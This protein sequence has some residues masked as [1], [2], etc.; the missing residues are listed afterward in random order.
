MYL[1]PEGRSFVMHCDRIARE[2]NKNT[3]PFAT[4]FDTAE[5]VA[6]RIRV[7]E[8]KNKPPNPSLGCGIA[9]NRDLS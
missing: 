9:D 2:N 1:S 7:R 8:S 6:Q 3:S 5:K 4:D